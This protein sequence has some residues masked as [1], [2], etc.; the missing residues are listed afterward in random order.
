MSSEKTYR[1]QMMFAYGRGT[2]AGGHFSMRSLVLD[3]EKSQK[4]GQMI[5]KGPVGTVM[6]RTSAARTWQNGGMNVD[7]VK[8]EDGAVIWVRGS[9]TM[10]SYASRVSEVFVLLNK[11]GPVFHLDMRLPATMQ[12]TTSQGLF[13][14]LSCAGFI[15]SP[16]ELKTAKLLKRVTDTVKEVTFWPNKGEDESDSGVFEFMQ[17]YPSLIRRPLIEQTRDGAAFVPDTRVK[18]KLKLKRLRV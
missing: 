2:D 16:E 7:W 13:R 11:K 17:E 18:R 5:A 8:L 9:T 15:L 3:V 6:T 14:I 10:M 4:Q 1:E 12:T